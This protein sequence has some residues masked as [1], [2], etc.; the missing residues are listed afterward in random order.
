VIVKMRGWLFCFMGAKETLFS[1][2]MKLSSHFDKDFFN[3]DTI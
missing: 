1:E 2:T 3:I